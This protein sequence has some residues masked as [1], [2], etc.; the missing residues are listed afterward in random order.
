[1]EAKQLIDGEIYC[2][3]Y[4]D[5]LYFFRCKHPNSAILYLS[6]DRYHTTPGNLDT[7]TNSAFKTYR[8]VTEDE[9]IVF[10]ASEKAR[11]YIPLHQAKIMLI[12]KI[13]EHYT[14]I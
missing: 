6:R 7:R 12:P 10:E 5:T 8:L 14:L 11:N 13:V 4:G 9:R 1:M 3:N 2:T